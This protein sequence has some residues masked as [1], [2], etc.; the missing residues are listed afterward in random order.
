MEIVQKRRPLINT[1]RAIILGFLAV[2]MIGTI[3]LMLPVSSASGTITGFMDAFFT[4]TSAVC[5]VGMTV[6]PT[7]AYWS[8][9]GKIIILI[10]IQLGGL[11]VVCI[12]MG[13]FILI[14][15]KITLRDRKLIQESFN[16]DTSAGLVRMILSIF[17]ATFVME[18]IGAILY[19]IRFIPEYGWLQGIA[20]AVFQS[21]SAFCNSGFDLIGND[22]LVKYSGDVLVN[23]TT[24]ILSIS[25]GL[26][27]IV[28]WDIKNI[29]AQ[30]RKKGLAPNKF[31][32]RLPLHSKV[33]IASSVILLV[34]GAVLIFL[35]EYDN[36]ATLGN[37]SFGEK[38]LSAAFES[39]TLRSAGFYISAT[40]PKSW[41]IRIMEVCS[42][43]RRSRIISSTCA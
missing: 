37:M 15:K 12:T 21:I 42:L 35:F 29:I 20:L 41:V 19:G 30:I 32:E 36:P 7:Y 39:V 1:T 16:L 33:V 10:L 25:G 17:K 2:I 34:S 28:W 40:T 26:G 43:S 3:L 31:V 38:I 4:S 13:F 9:F 23:V 22:S 6:V 27:F 8:I 11:G 14:G 24:M 18:G 5:V